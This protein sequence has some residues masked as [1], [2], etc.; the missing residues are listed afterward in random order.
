MHAITAVGVG[1]IVAADM[2]EAGI[3][4]ESFLLEY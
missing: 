3:T 2:T 4:M 1:I